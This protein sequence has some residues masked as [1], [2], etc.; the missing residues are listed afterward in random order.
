MLAY[1]IPRTHRERTP[2]GPGVVR[3]ILRL[4]LHLSEAHPEGVKYLW[5]SSE[6][7]PASVNTLSQLGRGTLLQASDCGSGAYR[8]THIWQNLM[9][10]DAME[11]EHA[12]LLPPTRLVDAALEKTRLSMWLGAYAPH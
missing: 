7:H 5:N 1:H 4:I 8:N 12:R 2:L 9:P 6:L 3:H 11:V 10:Q